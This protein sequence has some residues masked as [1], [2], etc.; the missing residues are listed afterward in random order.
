MDEGAGLPEAPRNLLPLVN[1]SFAGEGRSLLDVAVL[2]IFVGRV[3][4]GVICRASRIGATEAGSRIEV[5]ADAAGS[6]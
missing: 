1:A 5:G 6:W 3:L 4:L 2:A